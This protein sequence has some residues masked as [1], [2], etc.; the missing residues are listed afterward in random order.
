MS[1]INRLILKHK[2]TLPVVAPRL[3]GMF[4]SYPFNDI[5]QDISQDIN[6]VSNI[7][8]FNPDKRTKGTRHT[9][10]SSKKQRDL[11]NK[12]EK[13]VPE[14]QQIPKQKNNPEFNLRDAEQPNIHKKPNIQK[15]EQPDR[16]TK[17]KVDSLERQVD[18]NNPEGMLLD[19]QLKNAPEPF[20]PDKQPVSEIDD[21]TNKD[22]DDFILNNVSIENINHTRVSN[23]TR[24]IRWF[25]KGQYCKSRSKS[26]HRKRS[27]AGSKKE[28]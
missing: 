26:Y 25:N 23:K 27:G 22:S 21:F 11:I 14:K 24:N 16:E 10:F 1:Y 3:P 5:N 7:S 6:Q 12:E 13:S 28:T 4:E 18:N 8:T 20:Q 19:H 2:E 9:K 15:E 17:I